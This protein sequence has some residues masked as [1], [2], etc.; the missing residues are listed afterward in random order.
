[1]DHVAAGLLVGS[2]FGVQDFGYSEI[3][4]ETG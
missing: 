2:V 4:P 3:Q 1:M